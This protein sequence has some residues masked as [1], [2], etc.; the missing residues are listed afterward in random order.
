MQVIL[1]SGGPI[2]TVQR[3]YRD[4]EEVSCRWDTNSGYQIATFRI[5]ML[6]LLVEIT[7]E[8]IEERPI[9]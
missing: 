3:Y 8:I 9:A 1:K 7:P 4:T 6:Y 5:A 2:M